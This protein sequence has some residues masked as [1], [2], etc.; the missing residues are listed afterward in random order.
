MVH[1]LIS[2]IGLM[3]S[4]FS[5]TKR[6][7]VINP[8]KATYKELAL[9]HSRDYLEFVLDPTNSGSSEGNTEFGLEDVRDRVASLSSM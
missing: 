3:S 9:Y 5:D 4:D 6:I 2:S 1:S 8:I 7:Q